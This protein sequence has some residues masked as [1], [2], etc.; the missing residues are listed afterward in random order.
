M[1]SS[2]LKQQDEMSA[3]GTAGCSVCSFNDWVNC[4]KL[5]MRTK[6]TQAAE[7]EDRQFYS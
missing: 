2:K 5:R 4:L 7:D 6:R 1:T 3:T